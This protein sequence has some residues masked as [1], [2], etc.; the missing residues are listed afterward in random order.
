M[1]GPNIQ[2]ITNSN[3]STKNNNSGQTS[4]FIV[5]L[6]MIKI[7]YS[8]VPESIVF[9]AKLVILPIH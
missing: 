7:T 4:Q 1:G 3:N 2:V 8:H 6:L 9:T 5:S